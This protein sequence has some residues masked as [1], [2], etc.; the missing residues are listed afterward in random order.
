MSEQMSEPLGE[1]EKQMNEP[2]DETGK[3]M[4]ERLLFRALN[5][6]ENTVLAVMTLALVLLAGGEIVGR[7]FD[8]GG[9]Q[10][11]VL[12]RYL[13]FWIA[14][15]GA[16]AA[17]RDGKHIQLDLLRS[18]LD[19]KHLAQLQRVADAGAAILC[20]A[21]AHF[22]WQMLL[23]EKDSGTT[24]LFGIPTY[25]CQAI[26]PTV[27]AL[28]AIRFALRVVFGLPASAPLSDADHQGGNA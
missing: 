17:V 1:T 9:T 27:F 7:W 18:V 23:L 12:V 13:V 22:A 8:F 26:L 15:V 20:G 11:G 6:L 5:W 4:S 28:M 24:W 19:A 10:T 21:F 2:L 14:M 16:L 3:Q 25:V